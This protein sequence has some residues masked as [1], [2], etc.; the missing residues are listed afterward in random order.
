VTVLSKALQPAYLDRKADSG[1]NSLRKESAGLLKKEP[2]EA[3]NHNLPLS[4]LPVP[5]VR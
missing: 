3:Q 4:E 2:R 1:D 5:A